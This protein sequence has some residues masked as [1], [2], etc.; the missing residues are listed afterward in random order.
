MAISSV[1]FTKTPQAGDD[2]YNLTE[3]SLL[4]SS[5][6]NNV[7]NILTLDVMANDLGGAAKKLYS[8]D[9]GDFLNDLKTSNVNTGWETTDHGNRIQIV[10]GKIQ[11]DIS[12]AI[13]ALGATD[14]NSLS[15]TD[16]IHDSFT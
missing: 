2:S 11:V 3:D 14:L 8:I 9:N 4:S 13:S 12:H 6:Y 5:I 10:D 16:H 15:A 7:T 1:S